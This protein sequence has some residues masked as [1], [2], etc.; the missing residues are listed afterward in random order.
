MLRPLY[1]ILLTASALLSSCSKGSEPMPAP[2]YLFD[3]QW[4]L[5]QLQGQ[6]VAAAPG[7]AATSLTLSSVANTNNGQAACNTY[8]GTFVLT[9]GTGRLRFS[10]QL[11]TRATC[12]DQDL[13]TRYLTLL[14]QVE[15]YVISRRQLQLFSRE[16]AQPLLVFEAK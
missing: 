10:G 9:A 15:R 3:Q 6:G 5:T 12:P 1:L 2:V 16:S 4:Q 8:G 11:S 7:T 13:E 14:P